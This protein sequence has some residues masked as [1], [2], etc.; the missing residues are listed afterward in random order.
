MVGKWRN[1]AASEDD[2]QTGP[3]AVLEGKGPHGRRSGQIRQRELE[4]IAYR[5]VEN[6]RQGEDGDQRGIGIR[7]RDKTRQGQGQEEET[8]GMTKGSRT[9]TGGDERKVQTTDI[10]TE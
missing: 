7:R 6:Q 1:L 4:Q 2:G 10:F 5:E 9:T 3:E 8:I